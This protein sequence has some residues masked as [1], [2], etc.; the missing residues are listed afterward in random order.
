[1][2]HLTKCCCAGAGGALHLP[3]TLRQEGSSPDSNPYATPFK[4]IMHSEWPVCLFTVAWCGEIVELYISHTPQTPPVRRFKAFNH[5]S[6]L[7]LYS[8]TALLWIW[9][10]AAR[11]TCISSHV[12]QKTQLSHLGCRQ[13]LLPSMHVIWKTYRGVRQINTTTWSHSKGFVVGGL[14]GA[15]QCHI[16]PVAISALVIYDSCQ[17]ILNVSKI[18]NTLTAA[19]ENRGLKWFSKKTSWF[20]PHLPPLAQ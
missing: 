3:T 11:T 16:W 12:I 7:F 9:P 2:C 5:T 4:C 17:N 20:P 15:A 13:Y 6:M 1:M 8:I 10:G 14:W 19:T 18:W